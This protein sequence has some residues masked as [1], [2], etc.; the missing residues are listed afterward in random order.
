MNNTVETAFIDSLILKKEKVDIYLLSCIRLVGKITKQDE[1]SILL[2]DNGVQ[3]IIYKHA[4]ASVV[5]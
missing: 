4:I 5:N 1:L 2:E 3:Q